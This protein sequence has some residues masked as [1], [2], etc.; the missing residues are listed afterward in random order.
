MTVATV[1]NPGLFTT[2]QDLGRSGKRHLG[3]PLSGAADPVSYVLANVAAGNPWNAP[4]LECTLKGPVLRFERNV[5][6]ALSGADMSATLNNGALHSHQPFDAKKGDLL[7]LSAAKTGARCYIAFAGGIEG[8]EFLGSRS[9]YPPA[10][11]GGIGGRAVMENDRLFSAALKAGAGTEIPH[12][13]RMSLAHAFVLRATAGPESMLFSNDLQL[14]FA[15]KWTAG[16]RA[17]R[18]GVQLEGTKMIAEKHVSMA[19]SP[20]FPGT[21]QC[22]SGGTPFLLLA[23]AQ[24][25]GGY[26][27]IA[28]VIG[29]DIHLTGQIRPGDAIW[30]RKTTYAEAREIGRKKAVLFEGFVPRSCFL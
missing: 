29:A 14:F 30:F 24:T 26:P 10:S 1:I 5:T 15:G 21:V 2:I 3:V 13:L 23:D 25:V 16:R 9:T 11:L 17:D 8:D 4:A 18:M 19:S 28:Q 27:R 22:P 6:F 20:V 7:S 12:A